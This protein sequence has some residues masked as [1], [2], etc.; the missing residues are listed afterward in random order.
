MIRKI[1]VQLLFSFFLFSVAAQPITDKTQLEKERQDIQR[2]LKEIQGLYNKVKGQTKLTIGQL[3]VLNRKI[4]LQEQYIGSISKELRTIDDDIYLSE[5]EIYRLNKQI[6]TLKTQYARTVVYAYKNKSNYD[7]LNFIFSASGFNDA[8]KRIAYLK[9]YRTYREKQ[10]NIILE[11]QQLIAKRKEQQL[12]RKQSKNVALENQTKQVEELAVQKKVKA[13][14]V[15]QLKS[16]EK[17]LGN[18][19]AQ[20][21]KR[22]RDLNNAIVA[23]V[24][25]DIKAAEDKAKAEAEAKRK[26][27]EIANKTNAVT[28]TATKPDNPEK[29][30][31]TIAEPK[32]V[33][34]TVPEV[35][36]D[37]YLNLNAKDVA[38]NS[39]FQANRALLPWPVDNGV[40]T[41]GFGTNRIDNLSFD[42]PGITIATPSQGV[43]VKAVFEGEVRGIYNLGDGMAV[44]IRHGKY[45]T[46]YSN[47]SGVTVSKGDIVKTGQQIGRAGSNE[48]GN[49]GQID[50]ILMVE[51]KNVD[52]RP[53]LRR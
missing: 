43:T 37:S 8:I 3:A 5:L 2:E 34:K 10:V 44:T 49:A 9:S 33:K 1:A 13:E 30:V 15:S 18:Q 40:V 19:I 39:S 28:T 16:K 35:K 32:V 31:T 4:N 50:F 14:V 53:W 25:R 48:A 6:D 17:D 38:L 11:T 45:F 23:I 47:L 21:K 20:K 41:F 52:P 27:N 29:K 51:T 24:K 42:N 36:P 7:Y 46:T 22:D 26:A 12:G